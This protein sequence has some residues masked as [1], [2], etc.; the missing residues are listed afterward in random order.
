MWRRNVRRGCAF[1]G[2]VGHANDPTVGSIHDGQTP[3]L[4]ALS[5]GVCLTHGTAYRVELVEFVLNVVAPRVV[6]AM[7][8]QSK[9][10]GFADDR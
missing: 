3:Q 1:I 6:V 5:A 7:Y 8:L 4:P 9:V 10:D 2:N